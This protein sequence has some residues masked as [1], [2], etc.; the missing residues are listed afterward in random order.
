MKE[1]VTTYMRASIPKD[2]PFPIISWLIRLIT[3]SDSSHVFMCL[4]LM[5]KVF[6]VYFNNI[7]YEGPEYLSTVITRHQFQLDIERSHYNKMVEYFDMQKGKR[8]GYYLQ[9]LGIAITLPLRIIKLNVHNPF[10]KL[11][12]SMVCS[13]LIVRAMIHADLVKVNENICWKLE[14]WT[15]KD[16]VM[17]FDYLSENPSELFR[18]KRLK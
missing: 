3:W 4:P 11:Y 9:L 1:F 2:H 12:S 5:N 6:H 7:R 16:L 15:E 18:V 13:E 10:R 8:W 14:N 17:F